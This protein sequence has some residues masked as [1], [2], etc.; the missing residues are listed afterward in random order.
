MYR[1]NLSYC[2]PISARRRTNVLSGQIK[3]GD[4]ESARAAIVWGDLGNSTQMAEQLGRQTYIENLDN[5]FDAKR[6]IDIGSVVADD[7]HD[8]SAF[9]LP[10]SVKRRIPFTVTIM[11]LIDR[12]E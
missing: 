2:R 4:G 11:P 8:E 10:V 9:H 7:A 1:D 12:P 5:F 3:R 6:V